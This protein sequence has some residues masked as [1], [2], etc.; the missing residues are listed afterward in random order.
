[1]VRMLL[2]NVG[3]RGFPAGEFV[4]YHVNA[5]LSDGMDDIGAWRAGKLFLLFRY[6]FQAWR[7]RWKYTPDAFYYVPAPAKRSALYRDWLV[8]LLVA[9]LFR[10]RVF[11]WHAIGL[12]QWVTEGATQGTVR[13]W[14]AWV[15]RRLFSGNELSL[16]LNEQ[17]RRD[18]AIFSP[19]RIAVVPNG[20]PD[21]CPDFTSA[22]LPER[23]RRWRKQT[24]PGERPL[25]ELLYLAHATRSKGLFDAIDAV[26]LANARLA[27][28]K[29]AVRIR[30]TVAGAFL[31]REEETAFQERLQQADLAL[32]A[33]S[34]RAVIYAG[35]VGPQEKD[36]LLRGCD[37]LCFASYFPNEGQPVSVIEALAYGMPVVLSHWR[38]LP[39]MVSASLAHVTEPRDPSSLAQALPLLLNEGRFEEYRKCYLE[40][41][42]LSGHCQ[43]M[44]EA[45]LSVCPQQEHAPK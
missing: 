12:G 41:Y 29:S 6:I 8:L 45:F 27:A 43:R 16:V 21:P 25:F 2:E 32:T 15:T 11:H 3:S 4:F 13:R 44:R 28:E 5:R 36:R 10:V 17:G 34:D 7:L 40:R 39:E 37:A 30:L 35:Y 18:I 14:E 1:M 9:P 22:L 31:N 24:E 42:S 19:G 23:L 38:G 20:I 33:D 26:A